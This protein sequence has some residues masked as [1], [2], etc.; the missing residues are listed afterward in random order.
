MESEKKRRKVKIFLQFINLLES[1]SVPEKGG[2]K[3]QIVER[4]HHYFSLEES[5]GS[6]NRTKGGGRG[7][8]DCSL[9]RVAFGDIV[10]SDT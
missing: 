3:T 2:G 5:T 8:V 4:Y 1:I 10:R 6:R 7:G 9:C